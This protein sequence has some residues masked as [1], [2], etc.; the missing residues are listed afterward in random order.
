MKYLKFVPIV[1]TVFLVF[2][3]PILSFAQENDPPSPFYS[4]E[5]AEEWMESIDSNLQEKYGGINL[6]APTIIGGPATPVVEGC[7]LPT[8]V[9]DK[10]TEGDLGENSTNIYRAYSC[11]SREENM[12]YVLVGSSWWGNN[13]NEQRLWGVVTVR[14]ALNDE[15]VIA[16]PFD[17]TNIPDVDGEALQ[18]TV[19]YQGALDGEE[20]KFEVEMNIRQF[21]CD[22]G[23]SSYEST[24]RYTMRLGQ[25]IVQKRGDYISGSTFELW[26]RNSEKDEWTYTQKH[27]TLAPSDVTELDGEL[28]GQTDFI[29]TGPI[30]AT[31]N[32]Y[33]VVERVDQIPNNVF[34]EKV[35][36]HVKID[37]AHQTVFTK[38]LNIIRKLFM[39]AIYKGP[40]PPPP[41]PPVEVG[42]DDLKAKMFIDTQVYNYLFN[43]I[44]YPTV[45]LRYYQ[46]LTV[47]FQ[48]AESGEPTQLPNGYSR[49]YLPGGSTIETGRGPYVKIYPGQLP[50][51][52]KSLFK[53][54][55]L[56]SE[57]A[58]CWFEVDVYEP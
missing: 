52:K 22:N 50:Y 6:A 10:E 47:V 14:R 57:G 41:P 12:V 58:E 44:R 15:F 4:E 21:P 43:N 29:V 24:V 49:F 33:K 9:R 18:T 19:S 37:V 5:K 39:P 51:E 31:T 54:L 2:L 1:F 46:P 55:F 42:C 56:D 32:N 8:I 34:P 17:M 35:E 20:Y 38:F 3:L 40:K 27:R 28:V 16:I 25:I 13:D 45:T 48:N 11:F 23:P 36:S 26:G 53:A 7:P 30:T